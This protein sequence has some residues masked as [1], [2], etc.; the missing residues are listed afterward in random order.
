MNN[1]T[2]RMQHI[3]R[4]YPDLVRHLLREQID[5]DIVDEEGIVAAQLDGGALHIGDEC[6]R[7]VVLPPLC[8]LGQETARKLAAFARAGGT[9]IST[10]ALPELTESAA[11]SELLRR[12]FLPLFAQGGP[13][14]QVE[15]QDVA[16]LLRAQLGADL[17]LDAPN[18]DILYTHRQLDG[19]DVYFVINNSPAAQVICPRLRVPGPYTLYRPLTGEITPAGQSLRLNLE[20]YEGVFVVNA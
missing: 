2:E 5:L 20:G 18:A 17:Q 9:L 8:A 16:P 11:G 3:A 19:R 7:A 13:A 10:G 12:E 15:Q 14:A 4:D 6:Y 1:Q